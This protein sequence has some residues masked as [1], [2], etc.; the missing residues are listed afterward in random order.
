MSWI[1]FLV[2]NYHLEGNGQKKNQK[3]HWI[4]QY[5]EENLV[6]SFLLDE[7]AFVCFVFGFS[8]NYV[9]MKSLLGLP[10][11]QPRIRL[12][13]SFSWKWSPLFFI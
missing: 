11:K 6:E 13:R 8:L 1:F 9:P 12:L 5:I 7:Y 4:D 10:Q 2:F 3:G